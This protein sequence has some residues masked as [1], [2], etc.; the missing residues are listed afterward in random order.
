MFLSQ[1][2]RHCINLLHLV[3]FDLAEYVLLSTQYMP[4]DIE[5]HLDS[6]QRPNHRAFDM[7]LD[8]D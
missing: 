4:R 2:N 3:I 8:G 6:P 1:H 5:C 7:H